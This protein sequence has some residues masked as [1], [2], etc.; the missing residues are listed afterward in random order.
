MAGRI[1]T[2]P[3]NS[4]NI[5]VVLGELFT[6]TATSASSGYIEQI[7]LDPCATSVSEITVVGNIYS[8]TYT[9]ATSG[10]SITPT[11]ALRGDANAT[12]VCSVLSNSPTSTASGSV[13]TYFG[14]SWQLVNG[15]TWTPPDPDHRP[16]I[17]SVRPNFALQMVSG[18]PANQTISGYATV[19]E[20]F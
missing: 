20:D 12:L 16:K 2:I 7:V 9:R 15:W 3:I 13:V 5:G 1:Y 6:V 4:L 18:A 8:G 14:G 10:T 19:R 11:H 17:D